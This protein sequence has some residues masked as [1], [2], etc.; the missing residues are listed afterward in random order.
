MGQVLSE[1]ELLAQLQPLRNSKKIVFTNGCFD[2]LHVGHIRFLQQAREQGDILMVG[3]N[4]DASVKILE[5]SD[6]R[7]IQPEDERAEILAALACVS[8]VC[9]FQE[10]T[11]L[12]LIKKFQPD[13]LVKGGDWAIDQIIGAE[14][15]L[16]A[17]GEV[18]SLQFIP[19]RS[20][21][22]IVEKIRLQS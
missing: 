14:F 16:E 4:S 8:Y 15:V 17:G 20:T 13:V 18:K 2:I 9:L 11:P 21:T 3:L 19:G 6:D 5:K 10:A 1:D 12:E 22:D 7:P